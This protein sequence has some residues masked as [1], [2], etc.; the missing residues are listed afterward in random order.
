MSDAPTPLAVALAMKAGEGTSAAW[1]IELEAVEDGYALISMRLTPAMLNGFGTA[2]GG[3]IFALAD[4]AF[5]YACNSRNVR[6]VAQ[7]GSIQFLDAGRANEVL[8]AEARELAVKG[9]SGS[10]AVEV[11]GED[12]RVIA[13]MQGLSRTVGG[14]VIEE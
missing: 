14:P 6:T 12:D 10:Y 11:R 2:H 3:M 7:A 8:T 4:Q 9:R 5:A 13:T 1:R